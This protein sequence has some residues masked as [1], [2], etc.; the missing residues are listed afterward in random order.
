MPPLLRLLL[1][2][3]DSDTTAAPA[4]AIEQPPQHALLWRLHGLMQH[5]GLLLCLLL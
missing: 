1:L 5:V 2:P 3:S 4:G